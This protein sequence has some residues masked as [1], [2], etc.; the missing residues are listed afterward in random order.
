MR[1]KVQH[2]ISNCRR[3]F[4]TQIGRGRDCPITQL[5]A[6][7]DP[8][9]ARQRRLMHG[10]VHRRVRVHGDDELFAGGFEAAGEAEFADEFG[11]LV[12]EDVAAE[13]LQRR[14]VDEHLRQV[15]TRVL[16][17]SRTSTPPRRISAR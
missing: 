7:D 13:D 15:R 10:F 14:G 1:H 4:S 8:S 11:G 17:T 16:Q 9:L 6:I 3:E 2:R 12:A 5:L